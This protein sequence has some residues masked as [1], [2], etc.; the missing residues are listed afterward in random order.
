MN[1]SLSA[2]MPIGLHT[3][4]RDLIAGEKSMAIRQCLGRPVLKRDLAPDVRRSKEKEKKFARLS[5]LPTTLS[6][7]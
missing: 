3:A 2:A 6:A 1:A 4:R 7:Y 5:S